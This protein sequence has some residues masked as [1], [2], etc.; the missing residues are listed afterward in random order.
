MSNSVIVPLPKF[1][2][3]TLLLDKYIVLV[4]ESEKMMVTINDKDKYVIHIVSGYH[5]VEYLYYK[6]QHMYSPK[7]YDGCAL[8][9]MELVG[10]NEY[11]PVIVI[12]ITDRL[13]D[14]TGD[15]L[16][17]KPLHIKILN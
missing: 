8:T 12:D 6:V 2:V 13:I 4:S 17:L 1:D 10:N 9:I 7:H 16:K 11:K 3:L 15:E 14:N 5:R